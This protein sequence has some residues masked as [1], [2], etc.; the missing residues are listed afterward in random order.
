MKYELSSEMRI[1]IIKQYVE[2]KTLLELANSL[3]DNARE[4]DE[5][6]NKIIKEKFNIKPEDNYSFSDNFAYIEKE[7]APQEASTN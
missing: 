5:K 7:E 3:F 4:I 2:F 6:I 1:E